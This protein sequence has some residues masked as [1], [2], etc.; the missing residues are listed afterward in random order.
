MHTQIWS[1]NKAGPVNIEQARRVQIAILDRSAYNN[2]LQPERAMQI[3][4]PR[5]C[6]V[7]SHLRMHLAFVSGAVR[8]T[9]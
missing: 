7:K 9:T 3:G 8:F 4:S 2:G 1:L 6:Y 5:L